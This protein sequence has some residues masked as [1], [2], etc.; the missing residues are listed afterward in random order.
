MNQFMPD[1]VFKPFHRTV[2]GNNDATLQE[3]KEPSNPFRNKSWRDIGLLK[4]EVRAVEDER[5]P[6]ADIVI[7][8]LFVQ[9]VAFL[10]E[11]CAALGQ[12]FHLCVV[13]DL[14]MLG[15]KH[16]PVKIRV[17]DFVSAKVV[18]LR[19]RG[20]D[21]ENDKKEIFE[22]TTNHDRINLTRLMSNWLIS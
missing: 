8:L 5:D 18:E 11:L 19:G 20:L 10:G 3:F 15:L 17:L 21:E 4:M 12:L 22:R 9:P 13:V 2:I 14:E 16:L 1:D 6:P 7:E